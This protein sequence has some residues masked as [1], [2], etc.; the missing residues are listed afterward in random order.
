MTVMSDLEIGDLLVETS[1]CDADINIGI[2]MKINKEKG[3][4]VNWYYSGAGPPEPPHGEW[5]DH[6]FTKRWFGE[7]AKTN[8]YWA[9]LKHCKVKKA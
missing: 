4:Y 6:K 8:D 3:H 9:P 5:Y 1:L 2:V 7:Q